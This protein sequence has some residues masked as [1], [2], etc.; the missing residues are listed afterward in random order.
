MGVDM[1][2]RLNRGYQGYVGHLGTT[3]IPFA[4]SLIIFLNVFRM[5]INGGNA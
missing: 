2:I 3:I 1:R 4:L 5:T